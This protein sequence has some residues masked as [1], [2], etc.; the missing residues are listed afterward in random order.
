MKKLYISKRISFFSV[1][2]GGWCLSRG[3]CPFEKWD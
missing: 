1:S 3:N 2:L